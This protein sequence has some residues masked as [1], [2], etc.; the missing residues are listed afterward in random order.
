MTIAI[1]A[2]TSRLRAQDLVA[3]MTEDERFAWLCGPMA[4]PLTDELKAQGAI[5][6]AAF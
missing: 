5:G 3:R 1:A 4:I 2:T 6:S